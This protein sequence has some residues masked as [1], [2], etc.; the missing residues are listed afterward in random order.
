MS[1]DKPP[2]E[3]LEMLRKAGLAAADETP[4]EYV[5]AEADKDK[6]RRLAGK[7]LLDPVDRLGDVRQSWTDELTGKLA[8]G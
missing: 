6:I 2:L 8:K 3:F 5:T 1:K 4:V 7:L